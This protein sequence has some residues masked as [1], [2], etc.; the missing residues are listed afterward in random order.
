MYLEWYIHG[1]DEE[2][3]IAPGYLTRS[4]RDQFAIPYRLTSKQALES[5][6]DIGLT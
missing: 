2:E 6:Y 4:K 3:Y 1:E 5:M